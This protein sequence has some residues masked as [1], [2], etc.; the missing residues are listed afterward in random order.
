VDGRLQTAKFAFYR[1]YSGGAC[2]FVWGFCSVLFV[3][4][5]PSTTR[6]KIDRINALNVASR[7]KRYM[8][9]R[10]EMF[11]RLKQDAFVIYS[12]SYLLLCTP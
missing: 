1:A 12:S 7:K 5:S 10:N 4:H 8:H 9:A 11:S 6:L 3:D 2:V